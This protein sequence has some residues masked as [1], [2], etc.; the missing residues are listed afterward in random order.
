MSQQAQ[1]TVV[2]LKP[3]PFDGG[4]AKIVSWSDDRDTGA[5][6]ECRTC[7]CRVF[8]LLEKYSQEVQ[9]AH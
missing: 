8:P 2:V 4:E 7:A 1:E 6:I 9:K 3:C 5:Y